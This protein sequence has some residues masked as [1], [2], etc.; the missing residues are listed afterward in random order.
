MGVKF[1]YQHGAVNEFGNMLIVGKLYSLLIFI[2][3]SEHFF[4]LDT[5]Y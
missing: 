1:I 3:L 4:I 2:S 5:V